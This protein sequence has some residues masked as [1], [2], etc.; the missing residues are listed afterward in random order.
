MNRRG[1]LLSITSFLALSITLTL[2]NIRQSKAIRPPGV[3]NEDNFFSLCIRCNRCADVCPTKGIKPDNSNLFTLGTPILDGYCAV[4]LDL[5]ELTPSKN[6]AF[7]RIKSSAELCF[8]CIDTCPT[9]A[10][11]SVDVEE[12]KMGEAEVNRSLC[13]AWTHNICYR[14]V[15]ICVFDA[16]KITARG[17]VEVN[18][19][20]CV[21]CKQC[22][23]IC[24]VPEKATR[25]KLS[26]YTSEGQRLRSRRGQA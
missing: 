1:F 21:G 22:E 16:V 25:V 12:L 13:L 17:G 15:D 11:E 18:R 9:G 26:D 7:K 14:C 4:Y 10:L 23:Y 19:S 5:V 6:R 24:P 3:V 8:R 2:T 20:I